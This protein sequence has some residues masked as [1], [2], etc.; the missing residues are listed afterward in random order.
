MKIISLIASYT[1]TNPYVKVVYDELKKVGEVIIFTTEIPPFECEYKIFDKSIATHLV[2][3]P[4]KWICENITKDWDYVIYNEDDILITE[5]VVNRVIEL[6]SN[7]KNENSIYGFIRYEIDNG[8]K[9]WI[10]M[11]PFH[12]INRGS[13]GTIK[14]KYNDIL[15]F[16]PWNVHSGNW[17]FHKN[18]IIKMIEANQFETY[19]LQYGLNYCSPLESAA[20]LPYLR[21]QKLI[22]YDYEA[23]GVH[24]LPN[25]Y[26]KMG[27]QI[28]NIFYE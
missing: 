15:S 25:K 6:N 27:E 9:Y 14:N 21:I 23:V 7:K 19:H 4:R 22:P 3:E 1:P 24:H 16:E 10:D 8:V 5:E 12:A 26:V 13:R 2:Y 17:I 28:S 11:H 18:D 20:S